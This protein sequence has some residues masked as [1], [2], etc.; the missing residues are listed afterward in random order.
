VPTLIFRLLGRPGTVSY[1]TAMALA[2][3]LAAMTA[4]LVLL[5][6]RLRGNEAGTF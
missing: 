1:G 3:I 4:L 5:V 6:D 2:V